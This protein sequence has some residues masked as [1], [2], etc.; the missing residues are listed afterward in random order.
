MLLLL[1][2]AVGRAQ[3][4]PQ[5]GHYMYL[6][7]AYN[8]AAAGEGNLMKVSGMHRMQFTGI[9]GAPMSTYFNFSSPFLIGKTKH[10]AGVRFLNDSYGLWSNQ[11]FHVQYAYRHKIGKGY[12]SAGIELGFLN[13]KFS[14]D[15]VNL[16]QLG[17][18]EYHSDN[19][20]VIPA[21][22]A[23]G[24]SFDLGAGVYY[25]TNRWWAGISYAHITQPKAELTTQSATE[26][27]EL[28][29]RGTMY[30]H[31]GYKF[32]LKSNR[33]FALI[34]SA[35]L[36]TD[37]RSWDL[38]LNLMTEFKERYRWGLSYRVAANVAVLLG[39]EIV[40]GLNLGYTYELPTSKLLLESYGSHEVYLS[41]GFDI[42]RP[43]RTNRYK[44]IRYL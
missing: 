18:S 37:F 26:G 20:P 38:N 7:T 12:L 28:K 41:Y 22:E 15:S 30:A 23:S 9:N 8:P 40:S 34:P 4:D 10:A 13:I 3:F 27:S 5:I 32:V 36:M 33:D 29:V 6:P 43:R 21:G 2:A 14:G 25:N 39:V 16:S 11:T 1:C 19:D 35:F 24:M 31:G 44:S 42:L 17:E